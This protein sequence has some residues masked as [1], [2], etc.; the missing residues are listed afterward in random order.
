MDIIKS[1]FDLNLYKVFYMVAQTKNISKASELLYVSQPAVSY[2]IKMLEETLGGK[3]FYR[4][5][6]G[7]EL[8]PE[9]EK[10]YEA[11]RDSFKTLE[12]GEK[13]FK[14]DKELKSGVLNI[15]CNPSLFQI[16][17]YTY[18]E[19]FHEQYPGIKIHIISK[20]SNDLI[21]MLENHQIDMVIRKFG[22]DTKLKN[23]SVR[24]LKEITHCFFCNEK[25]KE[26]A[27]KENVSLKELSN[28]PLLVLNQNSYERIALDNDFKKSNVKLE[29]VIDFTYHSP[30]VY[31]VKIGYGIGYTVKE[32][33]KKEL[34]NKEFY[35]INTNEISSMRNLGIV[36][37]QK[38]I[39]SAA[40]K[41]IS[42]M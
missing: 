29:P 35:I 42:M 5:A 6:K 8:T 23:F 16:G 17:L 18:I 7:V 9:A 32:S 34:E 1:N 3:L 31:L 24:V 26:L 15:G 40:N 41:L 2:S 12:I 28:Y 10:L 13:I 27:L 4:T 11:I 25:Y 36:Y 14:E 33:I 21:K 20:P 37:D 22:K 39:S 30:I 19:K 38:Y